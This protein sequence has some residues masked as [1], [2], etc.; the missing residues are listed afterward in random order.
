MIEIRL[1]GAVTV[2][3]GIALGKGSAIGTKLQHTIR[4]STSDMLDLVPNQENNDTLLKACLQ[5]I[6]DK[7]DLS[8]DNIRI[9]TDLDFPP[10][11][12][13]KTS[14]IVS[15]GVIAG[16]NQMFNLEMTINQIIS[17]GA[18]AS[19][20]QGVSITGAIDDAYATYLGGFYVTDNLKQEVL[21]KHLLDVN[22]A[23]LFLIPNSS[24]PKST[25]QTEFDYID[26]YILKQAYQAALDGNWQEAIRKNSRVYGQY[27]LD[28]VDIIN[29]IEDHTR[30]TTGLNGAGPSCFIIC[31]H[32]N[33]NHNTQQLAEYFDS[34]DIIESALR[35]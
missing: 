26:Q 19:I 24:N 3:N 31:D 30:G 13:M 6:E 4:L 15:T 29:E 25:I 7:Y 14:S 33:I 12:G 2:L 8:I 9:E 18:T 20:N 16:L 17:S 22:R 10:A 32:E 34:F 21:A 11:K 5:L 28:D 1:G 27:Y 35:F 23:V